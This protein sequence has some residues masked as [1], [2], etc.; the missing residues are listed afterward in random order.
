MQSSHSNHRIQENAKLSFHSFAG[1]QA[2]YL[3]A[4]SHA[5]CLATERPPKLL[6]CFHP[7]QMPLPCRRQCPTIQI[8]NSNAP[9]DTFAEVT[10]LIAKVRQRHAPWLRLSKPWT[11]SMSSSS[12]LPVPTLADEA[13]RPPAINAAT[14]SS[15]SNLNL[16]SAF[17]LSIPRP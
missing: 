5:H 4:R 12:L 8:T 1:V 9:L 15:S 16:M 13:D 3:Q 14:S 17:S 10:K 2:M 7:H 6:I 11:Q